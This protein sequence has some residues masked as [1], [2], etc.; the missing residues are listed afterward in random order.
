MKTYV[1]ELQVKQ[2]RTLFKHRYQMTQY[3]KMN[4][5][6]DQQYSRALWKCDHCQKMDSES[7][8]I[9]CT[10]YKPLRENL[11]LNCNK[12]L[13]KYLQD[14]LKLR[15]KEEEDMKKPT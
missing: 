4:F 7:H 15:T 3:V 14:I 6:N 10:A 2:A 11:N 8:L 12:D 9:W 5:K 13:S 1:K